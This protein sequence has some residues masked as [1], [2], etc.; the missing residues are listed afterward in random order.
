MVSAIT[1]FLVKDKPAKSTYYEK[2]ME[3]TAG[4]LTEWKVN[5]L[6]HAKEAQGAR[7]PFYIQQL[8]H[9]SWH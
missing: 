5:Y 7:L 1:Q 4:C 3:I 6:P 8:W 9:Q 2:N